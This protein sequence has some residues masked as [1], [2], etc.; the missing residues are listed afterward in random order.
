MQIDRFSHLQSPIHG[1]DV[2]LKLISLVCM[3]FVIAA[4]RNISLLPMAAASGI[5]LVA[6]SRISLKFVLGTLKL[7]F[8]FI[9][10][11]APILLFTAGGDRFVLFGKIWVY[12]SGFL[13]WLMI[14]V[15]SISILMIFIALFGTSPFQDTLKALE[16]L[17]MP[18]TL[19]AIFLF[20]YRYIF[21]LSEDIRKIFTAARLRGFGTRR[22]FGYVSVIINFLVTLLVH[23]YEQSERV[24]QA[25]ALRG[26]TGKYRT[27]S[28]FRLKPSD[29]LKSCAVFIFCGILIFL[30]LR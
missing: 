25:M 1:W 14:S 17:K 3:V 18:S 21:V 22:G 9:L 7:P 26:F 13:V 8:L 19:I 2:R 12:S 24:S 10:I 20:T 4:S 29:G 15:K 27:L 11:M 23:S 16:Y 5:V 6:F 30:E 28:R